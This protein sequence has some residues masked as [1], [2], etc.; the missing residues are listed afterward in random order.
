VGI[1]AGATLAALLLTL[2]SFMAVRHGRAR[3]TNA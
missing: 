3:V 1:G 2:G